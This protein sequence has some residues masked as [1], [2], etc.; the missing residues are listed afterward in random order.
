MKKYTLVLLAILLIG[1]TP[2]YGCG[3]SKP[4]AEREA[5]IT[6]TQQAFQIEAKRGELI[7]WLGGQS[8]GLNPYQR[9]LVGKYYLT[10]VA[11]NAP[12]SS[13]PIPSSGLEGMSSLVNKL[14]LLDC[15]QSVQS[16]K[17]SLT[18]IYN[19]E[20]RQ[21]QLWQLNLTS[22]VASGVDHSFYLEVNWENLDEWALKPWVSEN[23]Y[24]V[25]TTLQMK[26]N[27]WYQLQ[28]FRRDVY[29][30]W[31]QLLK[32]HG[33]DPAKEGFTELIQANM[34]SPTP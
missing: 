14:S 6:F 1:V 10:G 20:I 16:I 3:P 7:N 22:G 27:A 30:Q 5:I 19:S 8:L 29:T 31:L 21:F 26:D 11:P 23:Y 33:I 32:Q 4:D 13:A 9:W 2:L 18:S 12:D 34:P 24:G 25:T 17:D 28:S 15:P